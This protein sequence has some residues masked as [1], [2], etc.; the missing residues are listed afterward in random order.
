MY[1]NK[2]KIRARNVVIRAHSHSC[3]LKNMFIFTLEKVS[4][5]ILHEVCHILGRLDVRR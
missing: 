2:Y 3:I 5:V 1:I 4:F